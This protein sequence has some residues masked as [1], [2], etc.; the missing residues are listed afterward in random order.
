[1]LACGVLGVHFCVGAALVF[2]GCHQK[3]LT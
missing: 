2:W 1:M 3:K